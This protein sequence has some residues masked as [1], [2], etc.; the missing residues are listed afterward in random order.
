VS[1]PSKEIDR[2]EAELAKSRKQMAAYLKELG[3]GSSFCHSL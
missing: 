2:L 1:D 3:H